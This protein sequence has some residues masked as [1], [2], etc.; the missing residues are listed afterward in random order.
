MALLKKREV[1]L[2]P[3][4]SVSS[5]I[6]E[7]LLEEEL[8][9]VVH[10]LMEME[11]QE[12]EEISKQQL[13]EEA[14]TLAERRFV[15]QKRKVC[16]VGR[17]CRSRWKCSRNR[18]T[19]AKIHWRKV[20]PLSA[21]QHRWVAEATRFRIRTTKWTSGSVRRIMLELKYSRSRRCL[22]SAESSAVL[23]SNSSRGTKRFRST[24]YII[25]AFAQKFKL[26][27]GRDSGKGSPKFLRKSKAGGF[28]SP[29][30]DSPRTLAATR[31]RR[32]RFACSGVWRVTS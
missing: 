16:S 4:K 31:M 19:F 26:P 13:L 30:S 25:F 11:L 6:R 17:S 2:G 27:R 21:R 23:E 8:K 10:R 29:T 1:V 22:K 24:D 15:S 14:R 5:S 7:M 12:Q 20:R 18:C 32:T 9:L 28:L 3:P